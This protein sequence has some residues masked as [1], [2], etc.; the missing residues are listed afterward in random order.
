M[1]SNKLP[2]VSKKGLPTVSP[3]LTVRMT[4]EYRQWWQRGCFP[5]S[6]YRIRI[7]RFRRRRLCE[8]A[9]VR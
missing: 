4:P 5:L 6:D 3:N 7:S 8:T 2:A 9:W 1:A